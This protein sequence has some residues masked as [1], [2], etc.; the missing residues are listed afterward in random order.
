MARIFWMAVGAGAAVWAVN[1]ANDAVQRLTPDS[2]SGT[3]ARGALHLGDLAKQFAQDVRSGMA[4]REEQLKDDLGLHGTAVVEPRS[5]R[6]ARPSP[7]TALLG[8]RS[9]LPPSREPQYRA[10]SAAPGRPAA[11]L[12]P[13]RTTSQTIEETPR[14]ALPRG[15][16]NRKDH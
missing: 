13:A 5:T 6:R 7:A 11:A 15:G 8:K 9:A 2:L 12:P 1:K 16:T 10:I 14:R 3:A 4:E